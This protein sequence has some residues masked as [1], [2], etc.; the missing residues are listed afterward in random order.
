[1]L[2]ATTTIKKQQ[3]NQT[4]QKS[5]TKCFYCSD[6]RTFKIVHA[7][8]RYTDPPSSMCENQFTRGNAIRAAR[9]LLSDY[10]YVAAKR[11]NLNFT[12]L[13][14]TV[15]CSDSPNAH[16]NIHDKNRRNQERAQRVI[17]P[18]AEFSNYYYLL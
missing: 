9:E 6:I 18:S 11:F 10:I 13:P 15:T 14:E 3:T 17:F 7:H 4:N 2:V 12:I 5:K 1:M 16:Y 8:S